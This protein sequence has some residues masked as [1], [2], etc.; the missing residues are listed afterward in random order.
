LKSW[1]EKNNPKGENVYF[2]YFGNTD[3][4]YYGLKARMLP[5]YRSQ[6][7]D[8]VFELKEGI[9]CI[10]ATTFQFLY[11]SES[12]YGETGFDIADADDSYFK[13]L[14]EEIKSFP[15]TGKKSDLTP[16]QQK[17]FRIYEYLRF[18]KLCLFLHSR[19]PD[20]TVGNSIL[21]F[22]VSEEDIR[23]ALTN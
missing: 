6:K 22:K 13:K 18:V 3:V 5:S 2:S 21:I 1:L 14:S 12:C 19:E 4:E 7:S 16:D 11:L 17:R 10:S 23:K 15:N 8:E 20:E 9:Y